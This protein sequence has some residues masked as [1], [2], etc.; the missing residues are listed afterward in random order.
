M[1]KIIFASAATL[2]IS[3]FAGCTA[4]DDSS[5]SSARHSDLTTIPKG[6]P[7]TPTGIS[8]LCSSYTTDDVK[9]TTTIYYCR[10]DEEYYGCDNKGACQKI[11]NYAQYLDRDLE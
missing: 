10:D 9:E 11:D 1:K 5:I 2:L 7:S 6:S 4:A 3:M 8:E